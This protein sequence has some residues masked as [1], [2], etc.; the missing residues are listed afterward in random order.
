MASSNT[1][2]VSATIFAVVLAAGQSTRFG[3]RKLTHILDGKP[4]IRHAL[5]AAQSAFAGNVVL[6]TGHDSESVVASSNGLADVVVFNP[7]F[8]SGQGSSLA[9]GSRACCDDADAIIVMLADQPLVDAD[10]LR[11]VVSAWNGDDQEIVVS[12]YGEAT[13]PPALFG[14]ASFKKLGELTGDVGAKDIVRSGHF[15][16]VKVDIGSRGMDVDTLQDLRAADQALSLE[17]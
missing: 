16:V 7:D 5:E 9:V 4:L 13:G 10:A 1:H 2:S 12:D 15:N 11:R 3:G 14:K 8:A 17:K 6:V